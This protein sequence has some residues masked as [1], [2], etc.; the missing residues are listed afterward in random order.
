MHQY[1]STLKQL[2]E[3]SARGLLMTLTGG[4]SVTGWINVELPSVRVPRMD[5]FGRLDNG[6]LL[7]LE[8]Q[9]T[10]EKRLAERVGVYYLEAR[11][12]TDD[13]AD[14]DQVVLYL[15]KEPMKM[16]C[17]IDSPSMKFHFRLIDIGDLDGDELAAS[18]DLGDAMLAVLARVRSRQA[19][20]RRVLDRIGKL[21]GKER[22]L[23]VEQLTILVGLRG[24]EVELREEAREYM[25]FVVDLMEN[26]IFRKRYERGV[27]Q[28]EL[29]TLQAQLKKRFGR[30]PVW[31]QKRLDEATTEQIES[32]TLKVLDARKLEDVLGKR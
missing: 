23:A 26:E 21:K 24:L 13:D 29:K 12:R 14:I 28:G 19:A 7:N 8:F 22:E 27:A 4:A 15:G 1:D 17:E 16:R 30:L 6:W 32:W 18:G 9:T 11:M 25:P 3:R 31:A 5:L 2:F 10:N 20:I